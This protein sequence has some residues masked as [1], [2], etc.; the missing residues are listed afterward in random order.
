MTIEPK[1]EIISP[2]TASD[3]VQKAIKDITVG[4]KLLKSFLAKPN[5]DQFVVQS[6]IGLVNEFYICRSE[7]QGARNV[8]NLVRD[9]LVGAMTEMV[10]KLISDIELIEKEDDN[11]N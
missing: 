11:T 5:Y 7:V 1:K 3:M 6:R 10:N 8:E 4:T 9:R 2:Q